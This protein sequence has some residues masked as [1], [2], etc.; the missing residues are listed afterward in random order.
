VT[1]V[2]EARPVRVLIVE[3]NPTDAKLLVRAL[4]QA[5]HAV[6]A[7]RVDTPEDMRRA[8]AES[9]WD[10][11]LSD[12]S[13]PQFTAIDALAILHEA[14]DDVPFIIV[15]GTVG[16]ELAVEAMR[17]G[18]HD[19]VLKDR[20][21]RLAPAVER[22]L[23]ERHIR[24]AK[25]H[26][27]DALRL[28]EHRFARLAESG[29]VGIAFADVN[30]RVH[31]A[32]EAFYR[33]IG[34]TRETAPPVWSE[35]TP[36]D[37]KDTEA[38]A[39]VELRETGVARPWEQELLRADRSRI[40]VL[41]GVAML[42]PPNCIAF[43]ADLSE[44][45]RAEAALRRSEEQLRQAQKMEAVGVLAGGIAHDFNNLLS[46]IL[47]YT[48]LA[49]HSLPEFDPLRTDMEEV[50]NAGRRAAD[51]TRQLL[52]FSRRQVMQPRVLDLNEVLQDM[53]K[54]LGRLLGEDI[55]LALNPGPALARVKV[56]PGQIEQVVMN[57]AVNARDAMPRGGML[58]IETANV[59]FDARTASD[60]VGT[61]IGRHVMLA[62]SDNGCGI[63]RETQ[64]RIFE[65]FF[66]TKEI[67]RGTG[68]GLSTVL[69]IVQQS[70]GTIWVYSERGVG[71]T[72]KVYLPAAPDGEKDT[73]RSTSVAL[74]DV[75]GTE[76]VLLVEDDSALRTLACAILRRHG[77]EVLDAQSGGDA[78]LICEQHSGPIDVLLTDVVMP[79]M[80]GRE[81][82][83]R[84]HVARPGMRV[85][86]MSGYTD[87][88]VVRHGILEADVAFLQK[89]ITPGALVRR[90][91]EVLDAT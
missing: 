23:R 87:D 28:S 31:D 53:Q 3:D 54:L 85:L 50:H 80:S 81:L 33:M 24:A 2:E 6:D 39:L 48:D 78:L 65:P 66:T 25:G 4:Q 88:T 61:T 73:G 13:M 59:E 1:E 42:D 17:A 68:L 8:L 75:R 52:A 64:A 26:T 77:Y 57:L 43:V 15:S 19:F 20:L 21:A 37:W 38:R 84:L 5:G 49:V 69:G 91:R 51:L 62:V 70:G 16:E 46:V 27:E 90:V 86:Y 40:P 82:A 30:G 55:Q 34:V 11:I 67:G 45:K 18:A 32:N 36:N 41:V 79:R 12:W 9:Q 74:A 29:I 63:D 44:R 71:T 22:E 47:S 76:T 10:V 14:D 83:E 72:F 89:P 7:H 56:D 35:L 60:H 58:T